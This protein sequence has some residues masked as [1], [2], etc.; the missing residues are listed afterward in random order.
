MYEVFGGIASRAFR[1]IWLLDEMGVAFTHHD[2][3][4]H[5]PELLAVNPSGKV[6]ALKVEGEILTDSSAIMTFLAD[7]HG[8]FTHPAGTIARAKQD[9]WFHQILDEVDA[10]LWAGARHSF[11]LPE[12]QRV[13]EVKDSLKWEFKR[14]VARIAE[15]MEGPYLQGEEI[16]I[17]DFLLLHCLNW[18]V[19][20]KFEHGSEKIDAYAKRIRAREGFKA[21]RARL[22]A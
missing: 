19:S 18:A 13:P 21:A 3:K 5:A 16:T 20:A 8:Q 1:V 10:V 4:P 2:L 7:K 14:N 15:R 17:A 12:A 6:P 11:I 22:A 9:G